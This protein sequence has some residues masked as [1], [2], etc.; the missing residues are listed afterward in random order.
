MTLAPAF[1]QKNEYLV[2]SPYQ[3]LLNE[4]K[5]IN[6]HHYDIF[7]IRPL[8]NKNDKYFNFKIENLN[9]INSGHSNIDNNGEIISYPKNSSYINLN[10]IFFNK[11]LFIKTKPTFSII[12]ENTDS[13]E[14]V[15]TFRYLNDKQSMINFKNKDLSFPQS[16]LALHY[17][18]FGFGISNE[19]MWVGPGFHSSLSLSNNS[20]GF[21]HLFIGNINKNK[22][23]K[24]SL[25]FKFFVSERKNFDSAFFHSAL[26]TQITFHSNPVVAFGFNRTY[27][28]GGIKNIDW[29]LTDAAKLVIEPLFGDSKRSLFIDQYPDE[30]IYWDPWDQLL[31]GF[32]NVFFPEDKFHF[33]VEIGTDD[34]RKNFSD[35]AV[36]WDHALGF[37]IGF[38]KY[39]FLGNPNL[40]I[41][42]EMLSTKNTTNTLNEN[43]YR[44]DFKAPNFYNRNKYYNS[45]YNG[46]RWAAHSGSDS[47]DKVFILGLANNRY[48]I[49]S[50]Y[51]IERRGV[52][53]QEN[54]EIKKEFLIYFK[55]YRKN[56]DTTLYFENEK[57]FNYNFTTTKLS[58]SNVLGFSVGYN[59]NSSKIL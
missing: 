6:I 44:G 17:K 16:T 55:A 33:Y 38:K 43:F 3:Y 22:F 25:D 2:S 15:G 23:K 28:S 39:H 12:S 19:N 51:N 9:F 8:F 37:N 30:P 58:N 42:L 53:S 5:A 35:L 41:G 52:I 18:G 20:H 56:I 14:F 40:F 11:F 59:F 27:L 50:S 26:A 13:S 47:D 49:I 21:N 54:P 36:H 57:I 4:K 34:S 29:N 7:N 31:I 48:S 24:F 46:R 1:S 32:F 10:I 45:S